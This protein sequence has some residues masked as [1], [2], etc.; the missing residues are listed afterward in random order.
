[1]SRSQLFRWAIGNANVRA[2]SSASAQASSAVAC[3]VIASGGA[4]SGERP[5][6]PDD[7]SVHPHAARSAVTS[8]KSAY[9]KPCNEVSRGNRG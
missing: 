8:S 3:A 2:R 7:R 9:R 6:A 5:A 1:M 4:G